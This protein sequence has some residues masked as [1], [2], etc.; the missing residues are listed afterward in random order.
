M[1]CGGNVRLV[2]L[3]LVTSVGC[4]GES[5]RE[6]AVAAEVPG[7]VHL[8]KGAYDLF[9][10]TVADDCAP[11]FVSGEIG[12][13]TL[14]V[15]QRPDGSL[16]AVNFPFFGTTQD[17]AGNFVRDD[18]DVPNPVPFDVPVSVEPPCTAANEE[19]V[20]NVTRL[21]AQRVD[22]HVVYSIAGVDT[23]VAGLAR[24]SKDC[25][26]DRAYQ[27]SWRRA[28]VEEGDPNACE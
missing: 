16:T 7:P 4:G 28:C 6:E 2:V 26:A 12:V 23:C 24:A 5:K 8:G 20:F 22:V 21:D 15:N 9:I 25:T 17:G 10:Q 14:F 27:F 3:A 19:Y 13:V 18:V 1:A 11:R